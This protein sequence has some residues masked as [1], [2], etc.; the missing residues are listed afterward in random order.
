MKT[1]AFQTEFK[2]AFNL[3]MIIAV[4]GV[5]FCICFDSWNDLIRGIQ[6]NIGNVHYFFWN[7]AFGGACRAYFLPIFVTIPFAGSFCKEYNQNMLSFIV[8]RE[9]KTGYCIIKYIVNALSGAV[10]AAAATALLFLALYSQF[11]VADM[12]YQ[13]VA[14]SESFHFWIAV[15]Q[16]AL[17]AA[18]EIA[19]GFLTGLLWSSVALCVS[20]YLPNPFV[21]MVS[22][23]LVSFV[24]IHAYRLLRVDNLYRLDKWLTGYSI[25][26]SSAHTLWLS[27]VWVTVIVSIMGYFFTGKVKR[28]I[29]HELHQ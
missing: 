14:V 5:I 16:P 1:Y 12:A 15:H 27:V 29:E 13:D 20:A 25:I 21:T 22:P 2:R 9:G 17:Y 19:N 10:V 28:R 26:D 6:E 18:V 23:Y 4:I 24:L 7:S 11:P 8:A 3:K